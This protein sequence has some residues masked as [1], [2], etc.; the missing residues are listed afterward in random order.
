MNAIVRPGVLAAVLAA[1]FSPLQATTVGFGCIT[2][3]TQQ[4]HAS[5]FSANAVVSG[6]QL[7]VTF[8]NSGFGS[9]TEIYLDAPNPAGSLITGLTARSFSAGVNWVIN[10]ASPNSLP[11]GNNASPAFVSDYRSES[12]GNTN[13]G[14]QLAEW[15]MLTFNLANG[16][17]QTQVN[18][19]L[20]NG[21]L[22]FGLHVRALPILNSNSTT[23]E[24][25]VS[26]PPPPSTP[27]VPE[28]TGFVLGSLGLAAVAV[29]RRIRKE[30]QSGPGESAEE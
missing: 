16:Q 24:V 21:S 7:N 17:G 6:S 30:K 13:N 27:G 10:I 22:R 25:F 8:T 9:I 5:Q 1:G 3:N 23:S 28:P 15:L 4:C 19:A 11:A 29:Y 2:N 26:T 18:Q 14:V 12:P 20:D